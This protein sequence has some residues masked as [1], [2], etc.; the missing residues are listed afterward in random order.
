MINVDCYCL[1]IIVLEVLIRY[2]ESWKNDTINAVGRNSE[3]VQAYCVFSID[4]ENRRII[5]QDIL[6][7]LLAIYSP[8]FY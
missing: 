7:F 1:Q 8:I 2:Y 6:L 5:V 3:R 4:K